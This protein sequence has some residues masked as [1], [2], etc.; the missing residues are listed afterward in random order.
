MH[1]KTSIMKQRLALKRETVRTLQDDQLRGVQGGTIS[2][3]IV[4][5]TVR[6]LSTFAGSG[7]AGQAKPTC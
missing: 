1:H 3:T 5:T 6:T 4:T 7:P 2:T